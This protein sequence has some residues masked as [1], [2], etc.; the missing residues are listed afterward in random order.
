MIRRRIAVLFLPM[1]LILSLAGAF[2]WLL[3]T[4]P[5]AR[6]TLERVSAAVPGQMEYQRVSGDLQSGLRVED[7]RYRQEGLTVTVDTVDLRVDLGFWPPAVTVHDLRLGFLELRSTPAPGPVDAASPEEW[8]PALGLPFPVEFRQLRAERIAWYEQSEI[9][10]V[11]IREVSLAAD[12]YR[13]LELQRVVALVGSSR[14]QGDL[15]LGFESPHSLDVNLL[16]SVAASEELG[17]DQ[18]LELRAVAGGNLQQSRWEIELEDPGLR[19]EGTLSDLL[20]EPGWDLQ[21][22][23]G[24]LQWPLNGTE[25]ALF[26][27]EVVAS[28]YGTV[29]DYGLE[30]DA[31]IGG[32][33]IPRLTG[34]LVGTG[35][36]SGLEIRSLELAG[37]A[38]ELEGAGRVDWQTALQVHAALAVARIDPG[39]WWPGW[40]DAEPV[41]GQVELAWADTLLDIDRLELEAPG[42]FEELQGSGTVDLTAGSVAARLQW[43]NLAW[44]PGADAPYVSSS[45]GS[46]VLGGRLEE[47]TVAGELALSGPDFPP[48]RLQVNGHGDGESLHLDVPKAAVLGGS[49]SGS[50][51]V[52]WLPEVHWAVIAQ[53]NDLATA[54]LAPE[55]PGRVSGEISV[56]GRSEPSVT[57]IGIRDLHG[58]VR[59]RRV[60]ASGSIAMQQGQLVV[61]DLVVHSGA[62]SVR[63]DGRVDAPEGLA[64]SASVDT[65]ADFLDDARGSFTGSGIVSVDPTKPSLSLDGTGSDL[66]WGDITISE[67]AA[68]TERGAGGSLRIELQGVELGETRV[69]NLVAISDGERPLDRLVLNASLAETEVALQLDGRV[70]DWQSPLESGWSGQLQSLRLDGDSLGYVAL[71]A[72]ADL[73]VRDGALTLAQACFRG[74]R[75]GRSCLESTWRPRGERRLEASLE[76]VSPNLALNLLGSDFAFTQ[77]LSGKLDWRQSPGSPA[78]AE[79]NLQLSA[80]EIVERG[81]DEPIVSTGPGSFSFEVA[82]GRLFEGK[83]DIPIEGTGGINADFSVPDLSAG[84]DSPVRGR[85]LLNLASIEPILRLFPEIEGKSGPV[86]ADMSFSGTIADPKFTGHASLVRG[87][88]SHFASGLLLDDIRLAGAVYQYDQTELTGSFR[89]GQG[90]GS[91]RA[92]LNFS[93]IL[94]PEL[95]LQISGDDL[96]LVNVPDLNVTA[97][98]DLR[99]VWREGM[100][101]LGGRVVI[102]TARLS[103]RYLP[104]S[105]SAESADVVIVAGQDPLA[106]EQASKPTEW[107]IRG[108]L[109]LELG[110][111]VQLQLDRAKAQL[112]GKTQ[113]RW[114]GQLVPVADGGLNLGGEIYAYGQLLKVTEGRI[115]FSGRPADNPFLN[116]RAERE[117][118]GNSQISRAG[119][120]VTGS[121]KRPILEPYSVPMTTRERALTLLITGSD[122]NYDQGVGTVEVGMY[123]APK[124]FIS[125][126]IGLF[127][128]QNVISARYD[129]GKGFGIKTTSGQRETGADISYTIER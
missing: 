9:P 29:A 72:P 93:E 98:P 122:I 20:A 121:L 17:I 5:G 31:E 74:S 55:L 49:L 56:R 28:S 123:V 64:F 106:E 24:H 7:L 110:D 42:T 12:W 118:Y 94:R 125:Y 99:L 73:H 75:E 51:D 25:P 97:N 61:R 40:G 52:T 86:A 115:N 30:L 82:D 46:A 69:E 108:E 84:L 21:L 111:D 16:L 41:R 105:A 70:N 33:G 77:L 80:G 26:L 43:R 109:E 14:W 81:E 19:V 68:S 53:L 71:E 87:T 78:A 129:L 1:L 89:A 100:L 2:A 34:R 54:P 58:I 15:A 39:I 32:A 102:P 83:L 96:T 103:P 104:T 10:A 13:A 126:G 6:W 38:A 23:A 8:L 45:D 37:D 3:H 119:V 18:P 57:E 44:P 90:Q 101:N 91:I 116:I 48:G 85:L 67:V 22:T 11:E 50:V 59:D 128:D 113:F 36:A 79:V 92:V 95:L 107:R 88:L 65:L 120:L 63:L 117:I 127:E 60:K 47:W 112:Q 27:D 66:A 4:E 76:A 124:L 114:D 35:D 62:S